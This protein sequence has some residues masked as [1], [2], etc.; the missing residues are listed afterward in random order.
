LEAVGAKKQVAL[1]Q[2]PKVDKG[3]ND[4]AFLRTSIASKRTGVPE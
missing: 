3:V 4:E 1:E 2:G